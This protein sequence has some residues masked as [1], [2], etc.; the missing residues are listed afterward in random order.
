MDSMGRIQGGTGHFTLIVTIEVVVKNPDEYVIGWVPE[1]IGCLT[2]IGQSWYNIAD[3][4]HTWMIK[5]LVNY[6]LDINIQHRYKMEILY[7][8]IK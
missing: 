7:F 3:Q 8:S 6:Q 2:L 5:I 4:Y 1:K